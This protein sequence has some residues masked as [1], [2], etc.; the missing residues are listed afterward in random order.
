ME[1]VVS[2]PVL[3]PD[4]TILTT[5]GY[6]ADSGLLLWL[7]DGL[8]VSVPE[9]PT[10]ADA[11]WSKNVLLDVV[12]DFP[13]KTNAHK[14]AWLASLLT[15]LARRAFEGTAPLTLAD[16]NVAGVGKGLLVDVGFLI[17]TGRPA[18]VMGYTNDK[19]ELRKAITTLA[20]EGDEMVLL[21]NVTGPFGNAVLDRALTAT[22]WKDRILG[23]N[24]KYDGPLNASWYATANNAYLVGDTPR[25]VMPIRLESQEERP[26]ERDKFKYPNLREHVLKNRGQLLSAALTILRA[27]CLAGRP[28]RR[29]LKPWGSFEG[30]SALLRGAVV[31]VMMPDPADT[32]E[33]LRHGSCPE[34]DALAALYAGIEALD[35]KGQGLTVASIIE[36]AELHRTNPIAKAL[37]E[38]LLV[39]CPNQSK[40]GTLSAQ[41][42]GMKLHHL[43]NRVIGGKILERLPDTKTGARWRVVRSGTSGTSGTN[44]G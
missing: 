41:S 5:P 8:E 14:S 7:P 27:Y 30:W 3:L 36:Q 1:G 9:E 13:F 11:V 31:W 21:D 26:E 23:G 18:S 33:D 28:Q 24:S 16:G 39:L 34:A 29:K 4:G 22:H 44:S 42:V 37:H 43:C 15:P 38:A 25:R 2:H 17:V 10:R 19:E 12:S 32:R 40:P 35:P 20:L 6:H